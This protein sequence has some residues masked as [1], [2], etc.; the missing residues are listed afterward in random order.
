ME[1]ENQLSYMQEELE[2]Q[3]E[4]RLQ[5]SLSVCLC[6]FLLDGTV[7]DAKRIG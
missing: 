5:V 4:E 3:H 6:S 2:A 7:A 1:V